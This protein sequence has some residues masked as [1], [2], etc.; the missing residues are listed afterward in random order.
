MRSGVSSSGEV[1]LWVGTIRLGVVG[2]SAAVLTLAAA[3]FVDFP[4]DSYGLLWI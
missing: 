2:V 4:Q 3:F 1:G